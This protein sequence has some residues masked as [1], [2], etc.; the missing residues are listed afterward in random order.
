MSQGILKIIVRGEMM[1]DYTIHMIGNAHID[2]VWLWRWAEGRDEVLKTYR[3]AVEFMKEFPD[4]VFTAGQAATYKWAEESDPQLFEEIKHYVKE[5][6]WNIVNGW[7]VQPDCN[8]PSGESFARHG[9]YGKMYFMEK[10]GV[11][12]K[13]GYNVDSFGHNR[14]LPQILKKSGFDYYVFM[15]PDPNE[16]KLE[17]RLFLWESQDKSRVLTARLPVSYGTSG[18]KEELE[19]KIDLICSQKIEG[20]NEDLCFYGVGDHGGGPSREEIRA[21]K[22]YGKSGIKLIFSTPEAFFAA[23]RQN[24]KKKFKVVRDDLQHHARGCYSVVSW[25]KKANRDAENLLQATEK[26]SSA[27]YLLEILP[28]PGEKIRGLWQK[29]LFNQFHDVMCG[30]SIP[31]AYD[32]CRKDYDEVF[33]A[34]SGMLDTALKSI[35]QKTD[36]SGPGQPVIFFNPASWQRKET[37]SVDIEGEGFSVLGPGGKSVAFQKRELGGIKK[38]LI[39]SADVPPT[40]FSVYCVTGQ[41]KRRKKRRVPSVS[42]SQ[43]S[44][45]NRYFFLQLNPRTGCIMHLFDKTNGL[46]M[47]LPGREGNEMLVLDDMSDTWSHGVA[48][49]DKVTGKFIMQG[50]PEIIE[51]GP[52]RAKIRIKSVFLNSTLEQEISFYEK[53]PRIDFEVIVDWHEKHKVLKVGFPFAVESGKTTYDIPG[54]TITRPNNGEEEPGQAW[55]DVAGIARSRKN[56]RMKYGIALVNDCKYGFSI[57]GSEARMSVLRSPIFAFHDPRKPEPGV[58][59]RYT[60]QGEH[61]FRYSLVPHKGVWQKKGIPQTAFEFNNPLI[62][63]R[64]PAH[65][66]LLPKEVSFARVAP[67]GLTTTVFKK[68]EKGENVILRFTETRGKGGTARVSLPWFKRSFRVRFKPYEIKT[69]MIDMDQKTP[70]ATECDMLEQAIK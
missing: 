3:Q 69:L 37:A 18:K 14:G 35:S 46:S 30:T 11:D 7:W 12:V 57:H 24:S 40:G 16:K 42:V 54:G 8:I 59:Y 28:Y 2:P 21:I 63:R 61:R 27:A 68:A 17:S 36:T 55:I 64:E 56:G 62:E 47:L 29:V 70:R 4:F 41:A 38:R 34:G 23:A 31:E 58:E 19:S 44:M 22:E 45:E 65:E 20:I 66:G 15:R 52:I 5:G 10:F 25:I 26:F 49:Y 32:D 43:Y 53:M 1:N 60:D 6:R 39:F 51:Q 50:K 9:L 48:A 13:V 33:S 67:A